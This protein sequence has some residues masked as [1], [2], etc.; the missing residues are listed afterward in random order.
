[1]HCAALVPPPPLPRFPLVINTIQPNPGHC[2]QTISRPNKLHISPDA[3]PAAIQVIDA[4]HPPHILLPRSDLIRRRRTTSH[5]RDFTHD[6]LEQTITCSLSDHDAHNTDVGIAIVYLLEF[7]PTSTTRPSTTS[8]FLPYPRRT[9]TVDFAII[10]HDGD[11]PELYSSQVR[12]LQPP[13]LP[14][15]PSGS[16]S[17]ISGSI[18]ADKLNATNTSSGQQ[19]SH[20]SSRCLK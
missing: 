1:M 14:A 4:P 16:H 9:A 10:F 8:H 19:C 15:S 2:T 7:P 6:I 5:S 12:C 20:T 11:R 18:R 13:N 3:S 17:T